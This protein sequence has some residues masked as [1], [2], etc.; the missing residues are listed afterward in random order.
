MRRFL[1]V[2][3]LLA[4]C[5]GA[6]VQPVRAQGE[7]APNVRGVRLRALET[8]LRN[9]SRGSGFTVLAD[10]SLAE[11]QGAQP[12]ELTTAQNLESQLDELVK[13]MPRGTTW[14]KVMLPV[15]TRLYRGD[16]VADYLDAQNRLFGKKQP[17]EQGSVEILGQKL[18]AEKA[19]PVVSNLNL[20]PVYVLINNSAR[21]GRSAGLNANG[22][23]DAG[24]MIQ[25]FMNMDPSS[26]QKM[27]QGMMQQMGGM[28]QNMSPEQ[29]MEFFRS[30]RGSIPG[31]PGGGGIPP[32]N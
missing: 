21:V 11:A 3:P 17:A 5:L 8:I 28:I 16:D 4:L 32:K 6:T 22:Q 30:M 25:S 12:K 13:V 2:L 9:L 29:R 10:S 23:P 27:M 20:K 7:D 14:A 24:Q 15:T 31:G 1:T 18:N 26:R 19:T